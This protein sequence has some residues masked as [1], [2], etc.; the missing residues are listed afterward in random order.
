[1]SI[2]SRFVVPGIPGCPTDM[3]VTNCPPSSEALRPSLSPSRS[4]PGKTDLSNLQLGRSLTRSVVRST[5]RPSPGAL[6]TNND[7]LAWA[8][9][10]WTAL[11]VSPPPLGAVLSP[12]SAAWSPVTGLN[13]RRWDLLHSLP[14]ALPPSHPCPSSSWADGICQSAV[15][16]LS[17]WDPRVWRW[18]GP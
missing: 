3:P 16:R 14:T 7:F 6:V 1:M 13:G 11:S 17:A 2:R 12:V 18:S 5:F 8:G 9:H 10:T 4:V 15:S